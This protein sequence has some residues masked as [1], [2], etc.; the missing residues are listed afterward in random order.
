MR[1]TPF[2]LAAAVAA[3]SPPTATAYEPTRQYAAESMEG[4][5]VLLGPEL[6][7]HPA[8]AAEV[9][10]LLSA[11]FLRLSRMIPEKAL[12]RLRATRVWVEWDEPAPK[13]FVAL[14]FPGDR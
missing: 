12:G 4:F 11:Q 9:R 3:L 5:K 2:L 1:A 6:L 13:E 7:R 10:R 8:E 14:F